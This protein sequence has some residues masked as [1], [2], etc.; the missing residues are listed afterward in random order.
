MH[1]L[2]N[3]DFQTLSFHSNNNII[4]EVENY[5]EGVEG[6]SQVQA[7]DSPQLTF[8]PCALSSRVACTS[9]GDASPSTNGVACWSLLCLRGLGV[10]N[11]Y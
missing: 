4:C 8:L 7:L 1:P 6:D 2:S 3:T 5:T 9:A 11:I 10:P